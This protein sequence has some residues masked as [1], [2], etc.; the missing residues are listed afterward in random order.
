MNVNPMEKDGLDHQ[1]IPTKDKAK[2]VV[3]GVM[4]GTKLGQEKPV[5]LKLTSAPEQTPID[6]EAAERRKAFKLEMAELRHA[7]ALE[8]QRRAAQRE[9]RRKE[10]D[11][12][13]NMVKMPPSQ[14]P[15]QVED[16]KN[17]PPKSSPSEPSLEAWSLAPELKPVSKTFPAGQTSPSHMNRTAKLMPPKIASRSQMS[18]LANALS[19]EPRSTSPTTKPVS[20]GRTR[21]PAPAA[22]QP[23]APTDHG[24]PS[25]PVQSSTKITQTTQNTEA[26]RTAAIDGSTAE[27]SHPVQAASTPVPSTF[28]S[29]LG[30]TGPSTRRHITPSGTDFTFR[31]QFMSN[32]NSSP[33]GDDAVADS[34]EEL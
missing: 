33:Y 27:S 31:N 16:Q 21:R 11:Q 14:S 5:K 15:Y 19:L 3:E 24:L 26:A 25:A 13:N 18:S 6:A 2:K 29:P 34:D 8:D 22:R 12:V 23:S 28:S 30:Q 4:T 10:A 17:P 7:T 1:N 32:D 9:L 20:R